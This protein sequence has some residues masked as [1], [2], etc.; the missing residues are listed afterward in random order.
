MDIK[1]AIQLIHQ[2][3]AILLLGAG[4]SV[5]SKNKLHQQLPTGGQLAKILAADLSISDQYPLPIISS[6]YIDS[7]G[8]EALTSRLSDIFTVET[9]TPDQERIVTLP[10]RRAY[11]LNYDNVVEHIYKMRGVKLVD[12]DYIDHVRAADGPLQYIHLH[13]ELHSGTQS[14]SSLILNVESY[15]T[16]SAQSGWFSRFRSDIELADCVFAIGC[17][18]SDLHLSSLFYKDPILQGK[19][20]FIDHE[21]LDAVWSGNLSKF[22]ILEA[23]GIKSFADL[24]SSTPKPPTRNRSTPI[25]FELYTPPSGG[26]RPKG[27]DVFEVV[28]LGDI[29]SD[30]VPN[31]SVSDQF[32]YTLWRDDAHSIVTDVDSP[33]ATRRYLIHSDLGNG[34]TFLIESLKFA[35]HA[36]GYTVL[37]LKTLREL[38]SIDISYLS[39]LPRNT[40]IFIEEIFKTNNRVDATTLTSQ[41]PH[42]V[43]VATCRTSVFDLQ[44]HEIDKLLGKRYRDYDANALSDRECEQISNWFDVNGLWGIEAGQSKDQKLKILTHRCS[45][46]F[47]SIILDRFK[48][49]FMRSRIDEVFRIIPDGRVKSWLLTVLILSICGTDINARFVHSIAGFTPGRQDIIQAGPI[50][51]F[52]DTDASHISIRSPVLSELLVSEMFGTREKLDALVHLAKKCDMLSN[53][54]DAYSELIKFTYRPAIMTAIFPPKDYLAAAKDLFDEL[55]GIDNLQSKSLF[56]LQYAIILTNEREYHNARVIFDTAFGKAKNSDFDTFQVD[57]HFARFLLESRMNSPAQ[58][59]DAFHALLEAH[60]RLRAQII[61]DKY[62]THPYRVAELYPEF[63][64]LRWPSFDSQQKDV[65]RRLASEMVEFLSNAKSRHRAQ[66]IEH[67][68]DKLEEF[69]TAHPR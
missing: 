61:R 50:K 67:T 10:W 28:M 60:K 43:Y 15:N 16:L 46:E 12:L 58:F 54:R 13:G 55:K 39:Q 65:S 9:V 24:I 41:F 52:I 6:Q 2:G 44:G 27:D 53:G 14:A 64:T 32:D 59:P 69:L 47:R 1:E 57:N 33:D 68:K 17:S 30:I 7:L 66:K 26:R 23:I 11:T 62:A 63:L 5:P 25:S 35:L 51:E 4:F 34:K 40:V 36:R 56:W 31:T 37:T 19:T 49:D 21:D 20:F 42:F 22:G 8:E 29:K 3:N 45:R 38:I 48:S 18:L